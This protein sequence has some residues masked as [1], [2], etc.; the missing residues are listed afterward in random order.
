LARERWHETLSTGRG[1]SRTD[2]SDLDARVQTFGA[3]AVL[4]ALER[5]RAQP[6]ERW[7]R[8]YL[9]VTLENMADEDRP[10]PIELPDEPRPLRVVAL[11]WWPDFAARLRAAVPA[12]TFAT[13]LADLL[14]VS[15]DE[16][17]LLLAANGAIGREWCEQ[18]LYGALQRCATEAAGRALSVRFTVRGNRRAPPGAALGEVCVAAEAT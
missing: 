3:A 17:V 16:G 10:P 15:C 1:L 12:A 2:R 5:M 8:R 14:P 13:W 7:C 11:P 18:R 9:D 4:E 6:R